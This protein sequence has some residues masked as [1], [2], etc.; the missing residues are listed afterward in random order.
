VDTAAVG[1]L[2]IYAWMFAAALVAGTFLPFLPASSELVLGGL[3]ASG[4][5]EPGHLVLAATAGNVLGSVINYFAGRYISG[6]TDKRWFPASEAQ[7]RRASL[8]F[9]RYG[10]WILL[11]SWMPVFGDLLTTI[12]GLLRTDFR[13]FLALTTLGKFFRYF[14]I[15]LGVGFF[16]AG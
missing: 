15:V 3:L 2:Q 7:M 8:Q 14:L 16:Q 6:M 10:F 12:A 11:M 5:G 9:N 13:L 4:E 1:D